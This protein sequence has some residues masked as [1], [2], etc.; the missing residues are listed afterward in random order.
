MGRLC[1]GKG[2]K[3]GY[4]LAVGGW[5]RDGWGPVDMALTETLLQGAQG[6]PVRMI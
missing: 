4:E 1:G 5:V 6:S 3:G 2:G